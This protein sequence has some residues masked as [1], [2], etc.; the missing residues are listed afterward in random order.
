MAMLSVPKNNSYHLTLILCFALLHLVALCLASDRRLSDAVHDALQEHGLPKG[1]V[2]DVVE[3]YALADDGTFE[4][5]LKRPCY[6]HFS[7]LVYYQTTITGRLSY[8][9]ITNLSGIQAKMLFI[10]VNIS[11]MKVEDGGKEIE[12]FVG[13]LYEKLDAEQFKKIPSCKSRACGHGGRKGAALLA[14]VGVLA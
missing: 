4:I 7:H 12:F 3:S 13:G 6:V 10:W 8:G 2:P 1:L 9:Q 5:H 11:A 14:Q